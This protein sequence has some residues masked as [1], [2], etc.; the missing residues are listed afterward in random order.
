LA[1]VG[2]KFQGICQEGILMFDNRTDNAVKNKLYSKYRRA[3]RN[4]N[5]LLK[6]RE[7]IKYK[8]IAITFVYKIMNIIEKKYKN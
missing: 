1:I 6:E 5:I 2:R 7:E 4:I 8:E 3:L